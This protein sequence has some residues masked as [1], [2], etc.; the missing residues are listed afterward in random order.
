MYKATTINNDHIGNSLTCHLICDNVINN[1]RVGGIRQSESKGKISGIPSL[2]RFLYFYGSRLRTVTGGYGPCLPCRKCL[3]VG[4]RIQLIPFVRLCFFDRVCSCIKRK[5]V[6]R[7]ARIAGEFPCQSAAAVV[8]RI[9][10]TLKTVA[11]SGCCR[12]CICRCFL[13]CKACRPG[14]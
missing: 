6:G 4:L 13:Q 3:T 14:L 1:T 10:D 8:N 2:Y 9:L 5:R 7:S 11:A 12:K